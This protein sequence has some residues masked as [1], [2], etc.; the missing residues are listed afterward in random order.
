MTQNTVTAAHSPPA[1]CHKRIKLDFARIYQAGQ[2]KEIRSPIHK[3]PLAVCEPRKQ[4]SDALIAS[5]LI[6][7]DALEYLH[8]T[9]EERVVMAE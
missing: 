8:I 3:Q 6:E 4:L 7:A 9:N 2:P 5:C 1:I